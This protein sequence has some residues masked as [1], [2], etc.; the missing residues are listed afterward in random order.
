MNVV[1][2]PK[3]VQMTN[4][5]SQLENRRLEEETKGTKRKISLSNCAVCGSE[6]ARYT[7]P[8]CL[9][10]SC[11]LLCVKKHKE[12]TGCSGVRDKTAFVALSQF[13][14]MNLL[15]DYRFLEDTGRFSDGATRD[16]LIRVPHVTMK[17][18][19]FMSKARKMNIT[20]RLLPCTFT[21][22][23]ENSTFFYSKEK[24]FMWHL[25][26]VFPHSS[27][28]FTQRR[29]SD[30]LTL[31][32]I[33]TPYIHRTESDPVARQKLKMYVLE[34]L[35][36][37]KVFMKA[38]GR[39]A[40][41]I[42]YHELD[43]H[44]SLRDNLS[45]KTLIEYPVL[46]VVLKQ[47]WKDY[48]LK[49]PAEQSSNVSNTAERLSHCEEEKT[50]TRTSVGKG[51]SEICSP[52]AKRVKREEVE[53]GKEEGE[54][55]ESS[56]EDEDGSSSE[57]SDP[58]EEGNVLMDVSGDMMATYVE[59]AVN[60]NQSAGSSEKS[61]KD[62]S[63]GSS[64]KSSKDQSAGSSEKSSK[65]QSAGSSEKSS[66][67]QSAG[68]SE[69]SSKDQS[70]GSSEKS[71]KDQSAGSSEKSSKDQS[72]DSSNETCMIRDMSGAPHGSVLSST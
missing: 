53:R 9:T 29:V 39:K 55:T 57:S 28:E 43:L 21:R 61:S 16:T 69:K 14:E 46:H 51:S 6:A 22:S 12:E 27:A 65:D 2:S 64:E 3:T 19:C 41:S 54:L 33:L 7:C 15:N 60:N 1:L 23:K 56:D 11:G 49:G 34:P 59:G 71:S 47:H 31:L 4:M 5:E 18:K 45:Y 8:R 30:Q 36:H 70:A 72:G 44:K 35:E 62:Q 67:D 52:Q 40:N 66:K 42:R 10:H 13:D 48:P 63:A 37:V 26:L 68:S 58:T 24:R 20:L 32:Q 17:A 25:K 50:S 38:E